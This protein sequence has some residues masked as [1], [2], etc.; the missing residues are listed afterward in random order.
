MQNVRDNRS[1]ADPKLKMNWLFT[2]VPLKSLRPLPP[3][4][5]RLNDSPRLF[6][7]PL[8]PFLPLVG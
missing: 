7:W 4:P 2:Y 6:A 3:H 8:E 5:A 1:F